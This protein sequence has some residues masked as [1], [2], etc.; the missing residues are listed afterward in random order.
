MRARE[1]SPCGVTEVPATSARS[2][3]DRERSKVL[4]ATLEQRLEHTADGR[5]DAGAATTLTL[6]GAYDVRVG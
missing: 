4:N 1:R 3:S 6:T 2:S 5:D